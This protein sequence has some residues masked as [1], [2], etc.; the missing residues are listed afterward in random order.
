MTAPSSPESPVAGG[1]APAPPTSAAGPRVTTRARAREQAR[2]EGSVLRMNAA[3]LAAEPKSVKG[4]LNSPEAEYWE[5]A[6]EEEWGALEDNETWDERDPGPLPHG[7]RA[8]KTKW[9]FKRKMHAD[10]SIARYKARLVAQ[11]FPK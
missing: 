2:A 7:R 5:A 1:A 9:V 6:M 11:G 10:G 4:A 3:P 8:I